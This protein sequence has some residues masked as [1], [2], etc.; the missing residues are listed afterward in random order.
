MAWRRDEAFGA[1]PERLP[2]AEDGENL[3]LEL[4]G[5][6]DWIAQVPRFTAT[7]QADRVTANMLKVWAELCEDNQAERKDWK[8]QDAQRKK[9]EYAALE[10]I[11]VLVEEH[12]ELRSK[13][14][15]EADLDL[16]KAKQIFKE[17]FDATKSRST[18]ES[19][20]SKFLHSFYRSGDSIDAHN[21]RFRGLVQ[22]V[23][24]VYGDT[25]KVD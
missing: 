18:K 16:A 14:E 15:N 6:A 1:L 17:K 4:A 13:I 11:R 20:L 24:R 3:V 25:V 9:D 12:D 10:W 21:E 22:N 23:K 2:V 7:T 5:R 19:V 8:K